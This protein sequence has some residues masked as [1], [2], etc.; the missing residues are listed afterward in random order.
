MYHTLD[1][2]YLPSLGR[3]HKGTEEFTGK[4]AE[5]TMLSTFSKE[6]NDP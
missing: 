4:F 3:T 5:F 2:L 6:K 1:Y